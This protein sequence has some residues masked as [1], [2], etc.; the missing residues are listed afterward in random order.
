M[1]KDEHHAAHKP[2]GHRAENHCR[3]SHKATRWPEQLQWISARHILCFR[4]AKQPALY[5][6]YPQRE[7]RKAHD[8]ANQVT[9]LPLDVRSDNTR[10]HRAG[11][12]HRRN[13]G[14]ANTA[15]GSGQQFGNQRD[16]RAKF[17]GQSEPCHEPE[18]FV[19]PHIRYE[20]VQNV[21][22]RVKQN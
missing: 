1:T 22:R 10:S 3:K 11:E 8:S 17:T 19:L 2:D 18:H 16:P 6:A 12:P 9:P 5:N 13:D 4:A 20:C 21:G 7:Q 14:G 15:L